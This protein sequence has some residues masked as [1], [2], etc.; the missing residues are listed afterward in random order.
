MCRVV[1]TAL[2]FCFNG[3]DDRASQYFH[4]EAALNDLTKQSAVM[5]EKRTSIGFAED[6]ISEISDIVTNTLQLY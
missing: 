1:K 3:H 2:R 6:H 5:A 4:F